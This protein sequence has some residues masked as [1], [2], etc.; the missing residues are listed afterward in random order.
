MNT[1]HNITALIAASIL[2]ALPASAI[3][4]ED[5]ARYLGVSSWST[6]V[7]LPPQSFVAELYTI[8]A[9]KVGARLLEGMPAW[10]NEPEKGLVIMLGSDNGKYRVV[11]AYGGG[12]TMSVQSGIPTF[13]ATLSPGL[14]K[15]VTAG[16][17]IL[18]G[19][20]NK[21]KGAA[22]DISSFERGF[23]LRIKDAKP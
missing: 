4:T 13:S 20:P 12:V 16:D 3:T 1:R 14:P 5:L 22:D 21:K 8:E 19:Q 6:S 15:T 10:S 17:Y 11:F 9:G 23:L 18:F 2:A 7:E